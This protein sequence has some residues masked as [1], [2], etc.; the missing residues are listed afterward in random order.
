MGPPP[1]PYPDEGEPPPGRFCRDDRD[2]AFALT[3]GALVPEDETEDTLGVDTPRGA[4]PGVDTRVDG[5]LGVDTPTEGT[6]G[7]DTRIDGVFGRDAPT[8]GTLGEDTRI[9]GTPGVD[10]GGW[11]EMA[12]ASVAA[13][14]GAAGAEVGVLDTPRPHAC[15]GRASKA[16][17]A[18]AHTKAALDF[19]SAAIR[20]S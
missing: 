13:G 16:T 9:E 1:G 20:S 18:S 3:D 17:R 11:L 14:A 10:T 2:G 6:L 15:Q 7:V 4:T 5:V 8:E 19:L 12:E